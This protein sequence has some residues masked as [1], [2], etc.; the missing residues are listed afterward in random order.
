MSIKLNYTTN[1]EDIDPYIENLLKHSKNER[2]RKILIVIVGIVL[3][4]SSQVFYK[5]INPEAL[6]SPFAYIFLYTFG[7]GFYFFATFKLIKKRNK[8]ALLKKKDDFIGGKEAYLTDTSI[9]VI[10]KEK[11]KK[12]NAWDEVTFFVRNDP[13]IYIHSNK[14]IYQ[15]KPSSK[16]DEVQDNLKQKGVRKKV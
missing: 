12:E 1:T 2:V 11:T 5:I 7:L 16:I 15:I 9:Q 4:T 10:H 8:K 13:Y 6:V 14:Y 3:L